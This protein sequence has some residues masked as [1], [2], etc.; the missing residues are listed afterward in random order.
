[1]EL[2]WTLRRRIFVG[3]GIILLLL[4]LVCV[5]AF[6]SLFRLGRASDAILSENY[7]SILAA[8]KMINAAERQDSGV[9]LYLLGQRE[10]G[11]E[12]FRENQVEFLQWLGRA[13]D[14]ITIPGEESIIDGIDSAYTAFLIGFSHL[15]EEPPATPEAGI[16]TY[17]RTMLPAFLPVREGST[18]LHDVNQQTMFGA[19]REA[20]LLARNALWSVG[21]IGLVALLLGLGFGMV[22]SNRLSRPIR[23]MSLAAARIAEGDYDVEVFSGESDELGTLAVRFNEMA[24]KLRSYRDMNVDRLRAEQRRG[25]AIIQSINDGI[26]VVDA[27]LDVLT[28]N[29]SAA[30]VLGVDKGEAVGRHFL[31]VLKDDRLFSYVRSTVESGHA[32]AV[33]E[34]ETYLTVEHEGAARH[35]QCV[36]TPVKSG[37]GRLL[38]AV[39]LLRDVTSLKELDRLKSEFVAT[40]SHELRTPLTSIGMSINLLQERLAGRLEG[41]ELE[42]LNVAHEEV[43][44]LRGLVSDLLDLSRIEAGKIELLFEKVTVPELVDT[45]V[46]AF[47]TQAEEAGLALSARLEEQLPMVQ[48]DPAKT[49]WVLNNLVSNAIRH[50]PP[51]GHIELRAE[52]V[53]R[54]VHV[55]VVDDGEGIPPEYLSKIFDKFVQV[56]GK[57]RVGGSGLG[58]AIAREIVQA[59]GGS[60]WVESTPGSGSTFTFSLPTAD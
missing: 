35:F 36:V 31:E 34:E 49:L 13:R 44:R 41:R 24:V 33:R 52:H 60:I 37:S 47:R 53:G 54:S 42:L 48:V 43:D 56:R 30:Q 57:R 22:L 59:H 50:T 28:L 46:E 7:R 17:H 19:S 45:A 38:G 21:I 26:V 20:R 12:Q 14:N 51:G 29:P 6:L 11:L 8:E 23:D 1:M 5:W 40:A 58:L 4:V 9:L 16:A 55:A 27:E 25:E 15:L 32:P 2:N 18:R 3:Y 39:L 10:D